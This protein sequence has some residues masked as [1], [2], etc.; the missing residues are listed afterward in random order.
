VLGE[1]SR[2]RPGTGLLRTHVEYVERALRLTLTDFSRALC[3]QPRT[4]PDARVLRR[5]AAELPFCDASFDTVVA[6]HM[7]YH[8]HDPVAALWEFARVLRPAGGCQPQQPHR[9]DLYCHG[10][11]PT[12]LLKEIH[13]LAQAFEEAC[14][15]GRLAFDRG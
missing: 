15:T 4:I 9:N 1:V 8:L 12:L 3:A 2:R 13:Q 5:D 6:N 10:G 7:P 11:I 14:R